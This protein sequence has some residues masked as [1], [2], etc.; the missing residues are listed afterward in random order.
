M[1]REAGTKSK[2]SSESSEESLDKM[3][4]D[5]DKVL[6]ASAKEELKTIMDNINLAKTDQ[7]K[8]DA[9]VKRQLNL[10]KSKFCMFEYINE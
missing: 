8:V 1:R 6:D 5:L 2:D 3:A 4:A 9:Y 7:E 10:F